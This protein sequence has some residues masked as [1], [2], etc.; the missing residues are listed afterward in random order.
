MK[1]KEFEFEVGKTY[2]G[3]HDGKHSPSRL[4]Q[5]VITDVI[6]RDELYKRE[7][8]LWRKAIREDFKRVFE[9]ICFYQKSNGDF[10][11]QF[12]DWNCEVFCVGY[13]VGDDETKKDKML[14][15]KSYDGYYCVNW[16]YELTEEVVKERKN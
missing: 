14:F 15:A 7:I 12:W 2:V 16:N 5:I 11:K 6:S 3:Y 10:T 8:R 1:N 13:I 9:G 4:V